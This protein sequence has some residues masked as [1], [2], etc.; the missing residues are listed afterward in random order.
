ME[1][2]DIQSNIVKIMHTYYEAAADEEPLEDEKILPKL[3]I[4]LIVNDL[5]HEYDYNDYNDNLKI[6]MSLYNSFHSES[7][8]S[9]LY[10]LFTNPNKTQTEKDISVLSSDFLSPSDKL[11]TP[12]IKHVYEIVLLREIHLKDTIE[13]IYKKFDA[14]RMVPNIVTKF[15]SNTNKEFQIW[16]K[17]FQLE[18]T[19]A[20]L[21]KCYELR[22]KKRHTSEEIKALRYI[23]R[24]EREFNIKD[25][26]E[27]DTEEVAERARARILELFQSDPLES[28]QPWVTKFQNQDNEKLFTNFNIL[29]KKEPKDQYETIA[30]SYIDDEKKKYL[31]E[32][33]NEKKERVF[34]QT[35]EKELLDIKKKFGN[36]YNVRNNTVSKAIDDAIS[37]LYDY[38]NILEIVNGTQVL[39]ITHN[40]LN[41]IPPMS[42]IAYEF[43]TLAG[44]GFLHHAIYMGIDTIIELKYDKINDE[45]I[46]YSMI[47][48]LT[49]FFTIAKKKSS[50]IYMFEYDDPYDLYTIA[51]RAVWGL[52][53]TRYN[54]NNSNCETFVNWVFTNKF[55]TQQSIIKSVSRIPRYP[56]TPFFIKNYDWYMYLSKNRSVLI[57]SSNYP[58]TDTILNTITNHEH[59]RKNDSFIK[60]A[61]TVVQV[62]NVLDECRVYRAL[63]SYTYYLSKTLDN[64]RLSGSISSPA[65]DR[66]FAFSV[67]INIQINRA[68][69][70]LYYYLKDKDTINVLINEK[71]KHTFAYIY[72]FYNIPII[73]ELFELINILYYRQ[74]NYTN[75]IL[76]SFNPLFQLYNI[77]RETPYTAIPNVL[78]NTLPSI[79]NPE[80]IE[81]LSY[82]APEHVPKQTPMPTIPAQQKQR[83]T[84]RRTSS[85]ARR[86][87]YR[88]RRS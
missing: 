72:K 37:I 86:R 79:D 21:K 22:D 39:K 28:F 15:N 87:S 55:E 40:L 35:V 34:K 14:D 32:Y 76:G 9:I 27:I 58:L 30:T 29:L 70:R 53:T 17:K 75:N 26:L 1:I 19:V 54:I 71:N 57:P 36:K 3:Y 12:T 56:G 4:R 44:G 16:S 51:K 61:N 63:Q 6:S 7:N 74:E 11:R 66:L 43:S 48:T 68:L 50:C 67:L 2:T 31:I 47:N 77:I 85:N 20:F 41:R 33:T 78:P 65:L 60:K 42:H 81:I 45:L 64:Y 84:Y 69:S 88:H 62:A 73:Q 23:Y 18:T 38:N 8:Y 46:G 5:L 52:G 25:I 10:T 24:V 83:R 59:F 82:I 13:D 49:N 80:Y